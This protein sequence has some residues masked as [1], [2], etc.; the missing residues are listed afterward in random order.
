MNLE[1]YTFCCLLQDYDEEFDSLS[2]QEQYDC[3]HKYY[4]EFLASK[5]SKE[6]SDLVTAILY[7][8]EDKYKVDDSLDLDNID[9]I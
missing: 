7:Y 4:K 6:S 9:F 5:Q 3:A 8:L 1:V 2:Y